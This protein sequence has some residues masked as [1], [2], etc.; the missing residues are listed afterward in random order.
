MAQFKGPELLGPAMS[1][2]NDRFAL[3]QCDVLFPCRFAMGPPVNTSSPFWSWMLAGG[4]SPTARA[5]GVI[6]Q[7]WPAKFV[8]FID[9]SSV[10]GAYAP[11]FLQATEGLVA[12]LQTGNAG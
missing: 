4:V 6:S 8:R 9:A 2:R 3:S 10:M 11:S 7:F 1:G 5:A 12:C